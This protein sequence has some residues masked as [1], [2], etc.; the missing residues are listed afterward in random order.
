M[1]P[2][3]EMRIVGVELAGAEFGGQP[4]VQPVGGQS[5]EFDLE[6]GSALNCLSTSAS[7]SWCSRRRA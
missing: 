1:K 2:G 7:L 3:S 4:F 6:S 5:D